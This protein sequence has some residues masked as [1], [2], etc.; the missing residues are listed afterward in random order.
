MG[1]NLV[2]GG[3]GPVGIAYSLGVLSSLGSSGISVESADVMLGTSA[4][5]ILTG[6]LRSGYT[7]ESIREIFFE[8]YIK[9]YFESQHHYTSIV[10]TYTNWADT[11]NYFPSILKQH[12]DDSW[13][14]EPTL[15]TACTVGLKSCIALDSNSGISFIK[16]IKASSALPGVYKPV[17]HGKTMYVDGG[18]LSTTNSNFLLKNKKFSKSLTVIIAPMCDNHNTHLKDFPCFRFFNNLALTKEL[19]AYEATHTPYVV[20]HPSTDMSTRWGVNFMSFSNL[21]KVYED[22]VVNGA[23]ASNLIKNKFSDFAK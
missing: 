13:P 7:V 6:Y 5:A 10:G 16:A 2:L 22:G 12:L 15:I 14:A 23:E 8:Q 19:A 18:L 21:E 20:I 1:F 17:Y 4:G 11:K 9:Q 3:G